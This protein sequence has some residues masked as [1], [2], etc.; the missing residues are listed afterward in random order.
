MAAPKAAARKPRRPVGEPPG[1]VL[2]PRDEAGAA[3]E[4]IIANRLLAR[5]LGGAVNCVGALLDL[6]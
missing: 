3:D 6:R 5:D 1:R 2:R 4:G